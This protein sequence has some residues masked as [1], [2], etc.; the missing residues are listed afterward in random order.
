LSARFTNWAK[1]LGKKDQPITPKEEIAQEA[2]EH[3]VEGDAIDAEPATTIAAEAPQLEKPIEV[4]PL[5]I[6]EVSSFV[7]KWIELMSFSPPPPVPHLK[8]L[9]S[10]RPVP[11]P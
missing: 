8:P 7:R 6:E 2:A 11:K 5:K 3:K 1:G 9:Q 4:E 10:S